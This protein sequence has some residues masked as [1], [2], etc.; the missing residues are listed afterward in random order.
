MADAVEQGLG[1]RVDGGAAK[2]GIGTDLGG[3][4]A[5]ACPRAGSAS[6]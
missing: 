2:K 6:N 4:V 1:A 5:F 3:A